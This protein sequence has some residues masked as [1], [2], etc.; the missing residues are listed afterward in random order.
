MTFNE[1]TYHVIA[2]N[3]LGEEPASRKSL[4][5]SSGGDRQRQRGRI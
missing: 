1:I 3:R 2:G 4:R 5:E